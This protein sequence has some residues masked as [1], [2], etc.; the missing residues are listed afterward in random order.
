MCTVSQVFINLT[1]CNFHSIYFN[2]NT[3]CIFKPF[4][5]SIKSKFSF[6]CFSAPFSNLLDFITIKCQ[7]KATNY[8]NQNFT[9][10]VSDNL[11]V[12]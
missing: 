4:G 1:V 12:L 3:G 10:L 6:V 8:M 9:F 11:K 7:E 5:S 2:F